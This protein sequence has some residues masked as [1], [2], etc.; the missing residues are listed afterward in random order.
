MIPEHIKQQ[1]FAMAT[2]KYGPNIFPCD[3]K[4]EGKTFDDGFTV[5]DDSIRFW[6]NGPDESTHIV[7]VKTTI[8]NHLQTEKEFTKWS[9]LKTIVEK[10]GVTDDTDITTV[11]I[12]PDDKLINVDLDKNQNTATVFGL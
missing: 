2:E 7:S 3:P 12:E 8:N 9:E 1:L 5:D 10:K 11:F 4:N 6:F